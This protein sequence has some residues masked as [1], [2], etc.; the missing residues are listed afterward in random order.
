MQAA[1]GFER[2]G[3]PTD[4]VKVWQSL[5]DRWPDRL[6]SLLGLG[7]TRYAAGDVAG[8][9]LA[10]ERA[11]KLHDSAAAWNNLAQSRKQLGDVRG[12][13]AAAERAVARAQAAEPRWLDAAQATL[14][15]MVR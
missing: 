4:S 6:V 9:A 15:E 1:L 12:A 10:F 3:A 11:A 7:N 5:L 14:A 13:R 8:A 2:L